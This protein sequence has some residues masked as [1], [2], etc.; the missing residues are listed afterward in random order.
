M[1]KWR[2]SRRATKV[3]RFA[4]FFF[5]PVLGNSNYWYLVDII[6][7][8]NAE[9]QEDVDEANHEVLHHLTPAVADSVEIGAIATGGEDADD[10]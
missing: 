2:E 6:P 7:Y 3:C 10:G 5:K 8:V 9:D 4:R 1:V